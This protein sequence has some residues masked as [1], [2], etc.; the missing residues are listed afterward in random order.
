MLEGPWIFCQM[1]VILEPYDVIVDPKSLNLHRIHVWV[2]ICGVPPL[3][4]KEE[5]VQD[6]VV[7]IRRHQLHEGQDQA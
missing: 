4:H 3:F 7:I 5:L 6:M 2:Q 1:G